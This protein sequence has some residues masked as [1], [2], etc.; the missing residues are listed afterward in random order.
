ML[1]H[2]PETSVYALRTD[3]I[4][5]ALA[6]KSRSLSPDVASR[7]SLLCDVLSRPT[8]KATENGNLIN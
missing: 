5:A 7:T 8:D 1:S 6:R 2:V 4:R 3:K